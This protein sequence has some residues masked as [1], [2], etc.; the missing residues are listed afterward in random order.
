MLF[1]HLVSSVY[2]VSEDTCVC[3]CQEAQCHVAMAAVT[4]FQ[5][6]GVV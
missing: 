4:C 1:L 5:A 3:H 2:V 6:Y